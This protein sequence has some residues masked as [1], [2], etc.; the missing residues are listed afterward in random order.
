MGAN[1]KEGL[2]EVDENGDVQN[3]IRVEMAQTDAVIVTQ[4]V[5]KGMNR[6]SKSM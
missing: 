3:A 2:T 4:I 5:K 6:H 1:A